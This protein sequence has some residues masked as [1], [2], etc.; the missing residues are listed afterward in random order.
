MGGNSTINTQSLR[1]LQ[2][3]SNYATTLGGDQN[4]IV[5]INIISGEFQGRVKKTGQQEQKL[6]DASVAAYLDDE[7]TNINC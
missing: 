4:K 2:Q 6:G 1:S 7:Y 5:D 3:P